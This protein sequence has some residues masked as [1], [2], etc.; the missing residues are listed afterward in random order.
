MI[1]KIVLPLLW[2]SIL[3]ACSS[4]E[5]KTEQAKVVKVHEVNSYTGE[6]TTVLPAKVK[7]SREAK[8]AF[9]IA[10]PIKSIQVKTGQFVRRGMI[11]ALMDDRDYRIQLS[12]T[13]AEYHRIKAEADRIIKLHAEQSVSDNDYDKATFGLQQ[14]TAKL[15]VHRNALAD[16]RLIAPYD[17]YVQEPF[18]RA[19]ETVGAGIPVMSIIS[20]DTPEIELNITGKEY[21]QRDRFASFS[22]TSD[23]FPERVFKLQLVSIDPIANMNQLHPMRLRFVREGGEAIPSVGT[24]AMVTITHKQGADVSELIPMTAVFER[25]S[26]PHV[27][28]LEGKENNLRIRAVAVELKEINKDGTV[29]CRGLQPGAKIVAAGAAHLQE[30]EAVR[31][32]PKTSPTNVGGLL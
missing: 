24:S 11:L 31:P 13:E 2:G 30:G 3:I 16:T 18:F 7:A 28:L 26:K 6:M 9:R 19:G 4:Q 20:G 1:K 23:L 22:C 10:G 27:W 17:G 14:I 8:L 32:T 29:V 5:Q 15:N 25:E 21:L 12:A